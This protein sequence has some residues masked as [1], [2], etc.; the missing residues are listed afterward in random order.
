MRRYAPA[1]LIYSSFLVAEL[2]HLFKPWASVV[3]KPSIFN[4]TLLYLP[5]LVKE[6]SDMATYIMIAGAAYYMN[7]LRVNRNAVKVL[8]IWVAFDFFPYFYNYKTEGYGKMYIILAMLIVWFNI[9]KDKLFR[10]IHEKG[11]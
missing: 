10:I 4:D 3:V 2:H 1:I 11:N 9:N 6:L 8:L 5:W 7:S